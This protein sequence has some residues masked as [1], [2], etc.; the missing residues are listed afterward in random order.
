MGSPTAGTSRT[1][2]SDGLG[3][4]DSAGSRQ[5][6]PR[7]EHLQKAPRRRGPDC[8]GLEEEEEEED[9]GFA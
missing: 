8:R 2:H 1:D 4:S 5:K 9:V 7:P 3:P 6:D